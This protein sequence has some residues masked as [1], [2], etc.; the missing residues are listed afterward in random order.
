MEAKKDIQQQ[1]E[2][3]LPE[4]QKSVKEQIMQDVPEKGEKNFKAISSSPAGR[5]YFKMIQDALKE[6]ED[7]KIQ[8]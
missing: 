4:L 2:A 7:Y 3:G 6:V 5:E 8:A 1:L